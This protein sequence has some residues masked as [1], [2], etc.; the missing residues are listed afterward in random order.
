MIDNHWWQ[1]LESLEDALSLGNMQ[2]DKRLETLS[3]VNMMHRVMACFNSYFAKLENALFWDAYHVMV[4]FPI[5]HASKILGKH[6]FSEMEFLLDTWANELLL[7]E[8]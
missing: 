6:F 1:R 2:E 5:K 3:I 4:K 8:K 7:L